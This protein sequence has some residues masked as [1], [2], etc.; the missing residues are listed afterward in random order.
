MCLIA[1]AHDCSPAYRLIVVANRDEYLHR[2][3]LPLQRWTERAG[4]VAGVDTGADRPGTWL[5]WH[6]AGRWAAVTNVREPHRG[7][8]GRLSRGQL[9]LRGVAGGAPQAIV[10]QLVADNRAEPDG[11][12]GFNLLCGDAASVYWTS[13]RADQ[14]LAL[15]KGVHGLS[16]AAIDTPWPKVRA[17]TAAVEHLTA[18]DAHGVLPAEA[19]LEPLLDRALA[20]DPLLPNTGMPLPVERS[21]SAAFVALS[22]YGTR[23]STVVRWWRDGRWRVDEWTHA[24]QGPSHVWLGGQGD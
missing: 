5:A 15:A 12:G 1:L 2:P 22:G 19:W 14:P 23:S 24:A 9:P 4:V 16:N 3:A 21:L 10:D 20:P 13:N 8:R 11:Y 18:Q 6:T 17:L 7:E